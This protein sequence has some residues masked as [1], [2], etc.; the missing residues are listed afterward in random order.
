MYIDMCALAHSHP[1][2]VES[3]I[4]RLRVSIS[5]IKGD[6]SDGM[7]IDIM[8]TQRT[9]EDLM[10]LLLVRSFLPLPL[11]DDLLGA[12]QVLCTTESSLPS[13]RVFFFASADSC[14]KEMLARPDNTVR[15]DSAGASNTFK[16]WIT[17]TDELERRPETE[18]LGSLV[19]NLEDLLCRQ[20]TAKTSA[21]TVLYRAFL[22]EDDE[23]VVKRLILARTFDE[24]SRRPSKCL[25]VNLLEYDPCRF[26]PIFMKD[27]SQDDLWNNGVWDSAVLLIVKRSDLMASLKSS[28]AA[29]VL[30]IIR[31]SQ[32]VL[33]HLVSNIR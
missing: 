1:N 26:S 20:L 5:N 11:L 13:F 19:S 28:G 17:A 4:E 30:A 29:L 8:S 7:E 10:F 18:A 32:R 14:V 27:F 24:K 21:S 25:L 12:L 15:L 3:V 2:P 31:R 9:R 6:I 33:D 23:T 22:R 16:T